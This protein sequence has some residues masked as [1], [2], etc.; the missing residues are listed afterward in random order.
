LVN[1]DL[2]FDITLINNT[3][4]YLRYHLVS[5]RYKSDMNQSH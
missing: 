4:S 1:L 5:N 3:I 2:V